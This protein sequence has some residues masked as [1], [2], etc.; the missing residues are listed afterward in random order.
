ME[1]TSSSTSRFKVLGS[2]A[3]ILRELARKARSIAESPRNQESIRQWR[4]LDE[5]RNER[6]LILTETDGGIKLV[7]PDFAPRCQEQWAKEEETRLF[8]RIAHFEIIK[9]D[10]PVEATAGVPWAIRKSS[11]GVEIKHVKPEEASGATT[12]FH[13]EPP[14][15]DLAKDFGKLKRRSFSVNREWTLEKKA[16]LEEVYDGILEVRI[17]GNPWWT[18][19]LTQTAIDLIGLEE[20]MLYMYDQPE[21]LHTL[22]DF[23]AADNEALVKWMEAEGLLCLNNLNDYIGSGSRGYTSALPQKDFT[24][25]ARAKDLW[26]LIE[27]Q[28]T[29][30]VGPELYEEFVFRYEQRI[31]KLF[32][33][34]YLGC[35]EPLHSRWHVIKKLENLKRLSISPWCDERFMAEALGSAYVYSRKPNPT[36]VCSP[37]FNESLIREDLKRTFELTKANNCPVEVIMKDV[38]SLCGE[39]GRL[40]RW[41]ELA[42]EASAQ[43]YG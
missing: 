13:I 43:I 21:A 28:E 41:V 30:G 19:G 12:A 32:G 26:T 11:Y 15:K 34:V 8:E 20:L 6:P 7:A 35:C 4:L 42:R 3:A 5:S 16:A 17:G 33:R 40:G 31:A 18:M 1:K 36:Q 39:P 22:M 23:L 9:D 2:D 27:S 10:S 29:V 38:H 24:G 25:K 37:E 14:L